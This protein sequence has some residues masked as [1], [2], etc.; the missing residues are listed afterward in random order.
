MAGSD[1]G[2]FGC[3]RKCDVWES[4]GSDRVDCGSAW[5][6]DAD[7]TV[8]TCQVVSVCTAFG[9]SRGAER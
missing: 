1:Q 7:R 5:V 2:V 4:V 3:P 8:V 6:H 9:E